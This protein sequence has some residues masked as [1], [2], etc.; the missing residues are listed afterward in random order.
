MPSCDITA[1]LLHWRLPDRGAAPMLMSHM[2]VNSLTAKRAEQQNMGSC[3]CIANCATRCI[4][5]LTRYRADGQAEA[6][7]RVL[8]M[9][10][11]NAP[12]AVTSWV[13]RCDGQLQLPS[14]VDIHAVLHVALCG[15]HM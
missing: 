9:H 15:T 14:A 2:N 8:L 13:H 7:P 12:V 3:R 5:R 4:H 1:H 11:C 10:V 6:R